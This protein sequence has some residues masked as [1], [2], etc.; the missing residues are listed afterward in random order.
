MHAI[1]RCAAEIG[2]SGMTPVGFICCMTQN[3]LIRYVTVN[4]I[5]H[6]QGPWLSTAVSWL[7]VGDSK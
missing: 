4:D 7:H 2:L 3:V 1:K 6:I 5:I